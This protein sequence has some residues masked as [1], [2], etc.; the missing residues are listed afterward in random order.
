MLCGHAP[1]YDQSLCTEE[2]MHKIRVGQF[3]CEGSE[4]T[5]VSNAAKDVIEGGNTMHTQQGQITIMD[6]RLPWLPWTLNHFTQLNL[7]VCG[8]SMIHDP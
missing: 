1:F 7:W 2:I 5:E 6:L 4:W 3:S 8:W